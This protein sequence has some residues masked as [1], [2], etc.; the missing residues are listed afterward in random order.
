LKLFQ[1]VIIFLFNFEGGSTWIPRTFS[2]LDEDEEITYRFEVVSLK[3]DE[4]WIVGM[5]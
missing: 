4:G 3:G 5:I 2:N 1:Y